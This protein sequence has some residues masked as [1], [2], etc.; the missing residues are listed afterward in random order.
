[1]SNLLSSLS[2]TITAKANDA[3]MVLGRDESKLLIKD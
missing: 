3:C 2:K 1:M